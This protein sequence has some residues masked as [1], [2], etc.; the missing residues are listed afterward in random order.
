GRSH[1]YGW[2]AEELVDKAREQFARLIHADAKD[3]IFTSGATESN[4]LAIKGIAYQ[5]R[6]KGNHIITCVTEHKSVLTT[7]ARLE[8]EGFE[9]DY[10]PVDRQ[11]Y[12]DLERL[13]KTIKGTTILA[14]FMSANNEI[15]HIHPIAQIAQILKSKGV[16]FH[17]DATQGI[18][19]IPIDV[20]EMGIDA[21]SFSAHKLHGPKGSGALYLRSQNPRVKIKPLMDGGGQ[22]HALRPGTLNVS[23]IVGLGAACEIAHREMDWEV[24]RLYALRERLRV[25]ICSQVDEATINGSMD[26]RLAN[27]LNLSFAYVDADTLLSAVQE[28]VALSAGSSCTS[29]SLEPSHVLKALGLPSDL[30]HGSIRFGLHRFNTEEEIDTVILCI[31]NAVKKL[32]SLSPLYIVKKEGIKIG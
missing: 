13:K 31:V 9:V 19:K 6:E 23:G 24:K 28:D 1:A 21:L 22:E 8:K 17:C 12:L 25:G 27:N 32:R 18:G 3:V 20:Q 14:S 26:D 2:Q 29:A 4:N 30:A 7:C 16:L 11:G 5:Y 15:G 10:L